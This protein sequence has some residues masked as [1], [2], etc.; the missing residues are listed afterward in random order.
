MRKEIMMT[1]AETS[2]ATDRAST[3]MTITMK[4]IGLL[5][6]AV[7][8]L[9]AFSYAVKTFPGFFTILLTFALVGTAIMLVMLLFFTKS[10]GSKKLARNYTIVMAVLAT[11]IF[12][13][14]HGFQTKVSSA[15]AM[16]EKEMTV[17]C[18]SV[19]TAMRRIRCASVMQARK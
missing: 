11:V 12:F 14:S 8:E 4:V 17:A 19:A 18:A 9:A 15:P 10:E 5:I 13:G 3:I 6:V 7:L 1:T 16:N 2:F